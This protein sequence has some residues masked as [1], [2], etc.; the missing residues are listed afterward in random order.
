MSKAAAKSGLKGNVGQ[1]S[2]SSEGVEVIDIAD[3][4]PDPKNARKHTP[5]NVGMIVNA[6]H[7]VGTGRSGLIDENRRVLAGNAT[8]EALAQAG[9]KRVKIV[10]SDGE[11]WVVVQ[12]DGL[13]E[14]QKKKMALYDNRTSELSFWDTDILQEMNDVE[15]KDFFYD[16]EL[17]QIGIPGNPDD[18]N[19]AWRGMPE[20]NQEDQLAWKRLIVNFRNAEDF[21]AFAKLMNQKMTEDTRSIWFPENER[22]SV[23]DK[24]IISES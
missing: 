6:L 9:I 1:K 21:K 19:A 7:E 18:P 2:G 15:L 8:L 23:A 14:K 10:K 3:L 12:R 24:L 4:L 22:V 20:F 17:V 16:Y 11:E 13:S 5:R